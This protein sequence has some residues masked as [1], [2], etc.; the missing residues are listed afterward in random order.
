MD[1]R[2]DGQTEAGRQTSDYRKTEDRYTNRQIEKIRIFCCFVFCFR[3]RIS[4]AVNVMGDTFAAA[5]VERWSQNDLNKDI[6]VKDHKPTEIIIANLSD[7]FCENAYLQDE[8]IYC[9][10][11]I[12]GLIVIHQRTI[13]QTEVE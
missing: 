10:M 5:I 9:S 2:T 7:E 12:D 11:P 3:D 13:G 6:G 8:W 4:T 1:G